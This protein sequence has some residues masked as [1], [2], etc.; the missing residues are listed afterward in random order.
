MFVTRSFVCNKCRISEDVLHEKKKRLLR[1][2]CQKC[3]ERMERDYAA[4]YS[5]RKRYPGNWPQMSDAM[6]VPSFQE[7]EFFEAT[8]KAGCPT[9]CKNGQAVI[10][11]NEHRNRL[12]EF[13][14][15]HDMDACYRQRTKP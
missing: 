15:M 8:E 11:S 6:G 3:Q 9:L 1:P 7:K 10:E 12:M 5:G 4:E 13:C 14:G 2:R